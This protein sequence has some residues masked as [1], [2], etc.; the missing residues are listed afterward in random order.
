M[1]AGDDVRLGDGQQI[2]VALKIAVPVREPRTAKIGFAQMMPLNHGAHGAVEKH[3]LLL[4]E[5]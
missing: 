5:R 3:Q 4:Q 1:N 2:V